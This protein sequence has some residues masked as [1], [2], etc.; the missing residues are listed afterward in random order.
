MRDVFIFNLATWYLSRKIYSLGR[1][2]LE[3][4]CFACRPTNGKSRTVRADK[5]AFELLS[6]S[7]ICEWGHTK[8]HR[9]FGSYVESQVCSAGYRLHLHSALLSLTYRGGGGGGGGSYKPRCRCWPCWVKNL[10]YYRYSCQP[11]RGHV[12]QRPRLLYKPICEFGCLL[13]LPV[14]AT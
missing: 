9:V 11:G 4:F 12:G 13:A 6:Q 2:F 7:E 10:V 5:Y 3:F 14:A 8:P 1:F